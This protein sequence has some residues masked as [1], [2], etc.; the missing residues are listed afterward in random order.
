MIRYMTWVVAREKKKGLIHTLVVLFLLISVGNNARS[1][2]IRSLSSS[3]GTL[4]EG[5]DLL[6]AITRA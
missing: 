1:F 3:S 6:L 5:F 2:M 4:L